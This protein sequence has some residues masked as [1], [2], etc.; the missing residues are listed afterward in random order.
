M[1]VSAEIEDFTN[2]FDQE[3]GCIACESTSAGSPTMEVERE[4]AFPSTSR[5]SSGI[6]YVDSGVLRHMIGV[7]EYFLKAFKE[8]H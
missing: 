4:Y 8:W 1:A 2:S 6:W 7:S 5:A 3:F